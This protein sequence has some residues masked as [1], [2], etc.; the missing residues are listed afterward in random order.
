ML[1][2]CTTREHFDGELDSQLGCIFLNSIPNAGHCHAEYYTHTDTYRHRRDAGRNT[3]RCLHCVEGAWSTCKMPC[4]ASSGSA[5]PPEMA[6]PLGLDSICEAT[7]AKA[8]ACIGTG[9]LVKLLTS[10]LGPY[11][12]LRTGALPLCSL[13]VLVLSSGSCGRTTL[14][15]VS[16][17]KA[18]AL[19]PLPLWSQ[20]F[21]V[22]PR[23]PSSYEPSRGWEGA[24]C[25]LSSSLSPPQ[26][27]GFRVKGQG[28]QWDRA[29]Q[30][31]LTR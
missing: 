15:Q 3:T 1:S 21:Q 22:C 26:L 29:L 28:L 11:F 18:S 19:L 24:N 12:S 25:S 27:W 17:S 31:D 20:F 10:A 4:V 2:Y 8:G 16:T 23:Q 5:T 14:W 13:Q 30:I 6:P 9:Y 7:P